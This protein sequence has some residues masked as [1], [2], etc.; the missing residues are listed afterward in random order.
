MALPE[1]INLNISKIITHEVFKRDEEKQIVPPTLNNELTILSVNG[2]SV[3]TDRIVSVLGKDSKSVEMDIANR[4]TG[5]AY[6]LVKDIF[7]NNTN[8]NFIEKSK[9][10]TK[11]LTTAQVSRNIPGGVVIIINGTSGY[12]DDK[13]DLV[14]VIKAELQSGFRK[15]HS[16]NTIE[17]IND[18]LLTPHQKMYKIGAFL[19]N[20]D[21]AKAFVYDYNISKTDEQGLA[22]YF[23]STFLGFAMLHT[24]KYFTSKFYNGTKEFIN[25]IKNISDEKKYDLN[26]HLYSYMKADTIATISLAD[27]SEYISD[28]PLKDEYISFMRREIFKDETFDRSI[29]KDIADIKSKLRT[30]R[31]EFTSGIKILGL[32]ED[33]EKN[34]K[35]INQK[36]SDNS[37]ISTTLEIIGNVRGI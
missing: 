30:R 2:L 34:V 14:L 26:T 10:I 5:S 22:T 29:T 19:Q 21:K 11:I 32:S 37:E 7:G 18:L 16:H 20:K 13:Y 8:E 28:A 25:S 35:I 23:Y 17:Y 9:D 33:F 15:T 27:F 6:A 31:M 3:L 36:E 4:G 12:G 24:N 1:F